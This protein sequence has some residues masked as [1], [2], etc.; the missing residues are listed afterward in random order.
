MKLR[1]LFALAWSVAITLP[2]AAPPEY[3]ASKAAAEKLFAEGSFAKANELYNQITLTNLAAS[4]QRWVRFRR[5]DTQWRSQA[6]TQTADTTKFDQAQREL[7]SL[8]RD[9]TRP[10]DRDR[11]W[12]EVQESLGDFFW[13]RGNQRN[14][15]E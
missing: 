13:T 8:V 12:V 5:A 10:D 14:W 1:V 7:E 15:G 2:A 9:S 3:E 11:V 4:E 6:A